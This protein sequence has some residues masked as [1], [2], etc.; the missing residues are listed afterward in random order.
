[1]TDDPM[2]CGSVWWSSLLLFALACGIMTDSRMS[3]VTLPLGAGVLVLVAFFGVLWRR[4]RGRIAWFEIGSVYLMVVGLYM[5]FPLIG[6]VML[7]GAYTPLSDSRLINLA[8]DPAEMGSVAWLYVCHV[9]GFAS[10]YLAVRGRLPIVRTG[11]LRPSMRTVL[12]LAIGYLLIVG[13]EI[14]LGLFYNTTANSYSESY[15]VAQRL[16]LVLAQ[17]LD[18]VEGM[19]FPLSLAILAVLFASYRTSRPLIILWLATAI[20]LGLARLGSRTDVML[21]VV[22]A[23][24]MYDMLVRPLPVRLIAAIAA[25]G[26]IGFLAF[27]IVR[28]G[29]IVSNPFSAT[30]EFEV[31]FAN[32]LHLARISRTIHDVPSALYL[33]DLARLVPQQ[34]VPFTKLDPAAWY[35]TR[36]FPEY[37]AYGGGLAFGTIA[38]AVLTGGWVSA[39]ARGAAL[40]VCF[41]AIHRAYLHHSHSF[42]AFVFYVW[43]T[44][45]CYQSFRNTTFS[46]GVLFTYRFLPTVAFVAIFVSGLSVMTRVLS[47]F[48]SSPIPE[49]AG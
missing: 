36:F 49:A 10:L 48:Q 1:M 25:I 17:L 15:L 23:T 47:R 9:L 39:L 14:G 26:L 40:G 45:L 3:P 38:E 7:R 43:I 41:A 46:L 11:H 35:V 29:N 12:A 22:S 37:A 33:A 30:T 27:G 42:W 19:K 5:S 32:A 2:I 13:F 18:H 16:P 34:L 44:T 6:Y 20:S 24:V 8:P 31:L 28:S 21:L 4:G